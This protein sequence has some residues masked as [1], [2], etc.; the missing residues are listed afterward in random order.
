MTTKQMLKIGAAL[1]LAALLLPLAAACAKEESP[2]ERAPYDASR[3]EEYLS[4]VVFEGLTVSYDAKKL[5]R[6]EA[7]WQKVLAEATVQEYPP[8]QVAYYE[9]QKRAEYRYFAER[10]DME[11]EAF[12]ELQGVTDEDIA[13]EARQMVKSDLCLL[14]IQR[15]AGISL[16]EEEKGALYDR[17]ADKYV[18]RHGYDR[19]Y[20]DDNLREEIYETMLFDKTMEYLILHNSLVAID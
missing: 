20:V 19:A 7:V 1:L 10:E 4:S 14:Y 16:T 12:L 2:A 5:T 18:E 3:L 6:G 9:A 8:E 13:K 17:Y 15:N 11:L